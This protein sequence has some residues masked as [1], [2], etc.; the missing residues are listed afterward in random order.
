[1]GTHH[2]RRNL[3]CGC[4]R[5]RRDWVIKDL[6]GQPFGLLTVLRQAPSEPSGHKRWICLCACGREKPIRGS[7]LLS[8]YTESCGC[9]MGRPRKLKSSTYLPPTT[10][11]G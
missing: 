1:M 3:S 2:L 4:Q 9:Q 10:P 5:G 8:G 11:P 6:T 7:N